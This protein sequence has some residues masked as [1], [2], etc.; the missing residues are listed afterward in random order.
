MPPRPPPTCHRNSRRDGAS[1]PTGSGRS[2]LVMRCILAG[3]WDEQELVT[4]EEQPAGIGQAVAGGVVGQGGPL[5]RCRLSA[6]G[7]PVRLPHLAGKVARMTLAHT[8]GAMLA[9]PNHEAVI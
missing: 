9:L 5:R 7:Q 1:G 6:Q 3:S 8:A 2:V 4:V